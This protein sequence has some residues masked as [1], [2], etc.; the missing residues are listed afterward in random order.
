MKKHSSDIRMLS[1]LLSVHSEHLFLY[2]SNM[3]KKYWPI[4]VLNIVLVPLFIIYAMYVFPPTDEKIYEEP[5][6]VNQ[7][8]L[9]DLNLPDCELTRTSAEH[10]HPDNGAV[11]ALD[12]HCE[13]YGEPM[14]IY[15]PAHYQ[16]F[17]VYDVGFH[18]E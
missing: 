3:L 7:L 1:Y 16:E 15:A 9:Q 6:N 8:L 13:P 11:Y 17:T 10:R 2:L 14:N 4:L 5:S 18:A 12:I